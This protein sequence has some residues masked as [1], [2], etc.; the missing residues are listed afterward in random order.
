MQWLELV[1]VCG[2]WD[3]RTEERLQNDLLP[4]LDKLKSDPRCRMAAVFRHAEFI[5]D[6]AFLVI[7]Q[8][9]HPPCHTKEVSSL[10]DYLSS[11]G[12]V[13]HLLWVGFAGWFDPFNRKT[14]TASDA[15]NSDSGPIPIGIRTVQ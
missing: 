9:E 4:E 1:R 5:G 8:G 12:M 2:A 13:E 15:V 10:A 3:S 14:D 11:F 7:W 6:F